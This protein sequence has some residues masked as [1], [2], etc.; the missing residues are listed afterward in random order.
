MSLY[1]RLITTPED[2]A[3]AKMIVERYH[4]YKPTYRV[5]GRRVNWL[6]ERDGTKNL[7]GKVIGMIGIASAPLFLPRCFIDFLGIGNEYDGVSLHWINMNHMAANWRFALTDDAHPNEAS[8]TLALLVKVAPK[9]WERKYGDPLHLII[10]LIGA[11]K[12]GASY[13]AANW[14]HIGQTSGDAMHANSLR[15]YKIT[16]A[17]TR[18]VEHWKRTHN[19]VGQSKMIFVKPLTA[20]WKHALLK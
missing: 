8:Q 16:G 4:S 3:I 19:D 12:N 2:N 11:G 6:I 9:E 13:R 17:R 14:L 5:I 1:L 7:H 18:A 15:G 20:D 10:T